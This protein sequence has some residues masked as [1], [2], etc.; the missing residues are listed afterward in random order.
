MVGWMPQDSGKT[1]AEVVAA[2]DFTACTHC[3]PD[4]PVEGKPTEAVV[5]GKCTNKTWTALK[6]GA[7]D[8]RRTY[9]RGRC[10][11][12]GTVASITKADKLRAHKVQD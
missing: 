2:Y 12:C 4:A 1:D 11:H 3:F 8:F 5:N 6:N 10:T 9:R 7:S